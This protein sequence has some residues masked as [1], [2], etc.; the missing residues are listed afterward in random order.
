[1]SYSTKRGRV[2]K[3]PKEASMASGIAII[4]LAGISILVVFTLPWVGADLFGERGSYS[5]GDYE[6]N[7]TFQRLM[8]VS[9]IAAAGS[10]ACGTVI[11][12][13]KLLNELEIIEKIKSMWITYIAQKALIFPSTIMLVIGSL[14]LGA[15]FAT[16]H[17]GL[18]L[19]VKVVMWFPVPYFL[20]ATG[21]IFNLYSSIGS[22]AEMKSIKYNNNIKKIKIKKNPVKKK[23]VKM[24]G[25]F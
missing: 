9:V 15:F 23:P 22:K 3:K 1:M 17:F 21:I 12:F 4:I 7:V 20:L 16:F 18:V 6:N 8:I 2:R 14:F 10:M 13:S 5:I 19:D 24:N 11:I 25:G